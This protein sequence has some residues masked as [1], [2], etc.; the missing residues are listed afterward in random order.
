ERATFS[1]IEEQQLD[2]VSS[3]LSAWLTRWEQA[4]LTQLM[5]PEERQRYF[6]EHLVDALLRGNSAARYAAYA[7]GRQWGWLSAN[8]VRERENMNPVE[9]GDAYLIPLNMI[10]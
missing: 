2:Y 4:V 10:P 3:A 5:L 8:D 6:P 1:N 9:G 7:I